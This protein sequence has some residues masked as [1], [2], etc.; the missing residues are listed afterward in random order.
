M[1]L[2]IADQ[3]TK[4]LAAWRA[5]LAFV[6]LAKELTLIEVDRAVEI[7]AQLRPAHVHD[8]DLDGRRDR[9]CPR[10]VSEE[11]EPSP[12]RLEALKGSGDAGWR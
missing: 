6:N 2:V 7:A 3:H 12:T 9:R 10:V 1:N 8:L 11:G 5:E 4:R